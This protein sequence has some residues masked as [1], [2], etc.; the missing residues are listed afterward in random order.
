MKKKPLV[1]LT[2][3]TAV[4]KTALSIGQTVSGYLAVFSIA[5]FVISCIASY[6]VKKK[7]RL[8]TQ[9]RRAS[10]GRPVKVRYFFD[11]FPKSATAITAVCL[12]LV[13]AASI[14]APTITAMMNKEETPVHS[15]ESVCTVCGGCTDFYCE[16]KDCETKCSCPIPCE[17]ACNTCGLCILND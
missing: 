4:G 12:V 3:P 9:R 14:V 5:M 2:G 13:I 6:G 8:E 16:E 17:H 1:I 15:C 10:G 11:V 7:H